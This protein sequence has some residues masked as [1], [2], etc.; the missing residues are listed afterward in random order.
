MMRA[1]LFLTLIATSG[2]GYKMVS[3]SSERYKTLA[4]HPVGANQATRP[5]AIRMRDSLI[6]SCLA[7]SAFEPTDQDGDL[8]LSSRLDD[9]RENIIAT[10]VDG[11]T[12]QIQ[13]IL[14][15]SFYLSDRSGSRLWALENYHYSDQFRI[16]TNANAYRDEAVYVQDEA[17]KSVA[18]L[19][20]TNINLTISE[21]QVNEKPKQE[22]GGS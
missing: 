15:A 21:Q 4:I 9:Y 16:S 3:W 17:M 10:D 22:T 8:I 11:R 7:G 20:I 12:A 1:C 13:F 2:C 5:M 6:E 18:D 14:K 19:V